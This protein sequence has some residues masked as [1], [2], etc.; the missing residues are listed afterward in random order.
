MK[1]GRRRIR[2]THKKKNSLGKWKPRRIDSLVE[3]GLIW[4]HY[5][6]YR[7]A[8]I[9]YNAFFH[10]LTYLMVLVTKGESH[11]EAKPSSLPWRSSDILICVISQ[12]LCLWM[13]SSCKWTACL[14]FGLTLPFTCSQ[15]NKLLATTKYAALRFLYLY[16]LR[17]IFMMSCSR[18]R[19]KQKYS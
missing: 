7:L 19:K 13:Q 11:A 6:R 2:A 8:Y 12:I 9:D 15:S 3:T 16:M 18:H 10:S 14:V 1:K 5:V 4:S 17:R